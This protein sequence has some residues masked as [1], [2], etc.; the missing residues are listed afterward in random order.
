M[1]NEKQNLE[2]AESQPLNIADVRQRAMSI[3]AEH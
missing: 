2:N 3:L 1:S